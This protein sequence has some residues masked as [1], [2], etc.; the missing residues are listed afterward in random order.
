MFRIPSDL[1]I[2]V[3]GSS[4]AAGFG[5]FSMHRESQRWSFPAQ[6]ARRVK[7]PLIQPLFEP[8]GVGEAPG[9]QSQPVIFPHAQQASLWDTLPPA[10]FQ[11]LSV[12]GYKIHD[13]LERRPV[14]PMVHRNDPLQTACNLI[15]GARELPFG[16]HSALPT[17]VER[18]AARKPAAVLIELGYIEAIH[19]ALAG[20]VTGMMDG[21]A[22]GA[23]IGRILANFTAGF[24]VVFTVPDPFDAPHFC[25]LKA[26]GEAL[27]LDPAALQDAYG[28]PSGDLL[29]LP[30]LHEIAFQLFAGK[31]SPLPAGSL[32]SSAA[33]AAIRARVQE[34]NQAIH[35]VAQQHRAIVFD[36]HAV[37][38]GWHQNGA[39]AGTRR[40]SAAYLGGLFRLNGWFPGN[41]G[42]ALIADGIVKALMPA[43]GLTFPASDMQ[44]IMETDPAAQC[45]PAGGRNWTSAELATRIRV[46]PAETPAPEPAP[47]PA[48]TPAPLPSP[49]VTVR[50]LPSSLRLPH[51]LEQVLP[52][53]PDAS[54]FGDGISASLCED[55]RDIRWGDLANH[56]FGGYAIVD[57]HLSGRLR[58]R[59]SPPVNQVTSFEVFFEGGFT[60]EDS[61]LTCPIF[62]RMPFHQNRVDEIPG[63]VS[64]GELNLETGVVSKLR[65]YARYS[66]QALIA[67]VGSN[68]KFP[69]DPLSFVS[70]DIADPQ[71]EYGSAWAK[72]TQ[73]PDGALDFAFYGTRYVPLGPGTRWPLNFKGPDGAFATI[74]AD[75][76]VMHPHLRLST[77]ASDVAHAPVAPSI[78]YNSVREFTFHSHNTAFGDAFNLDI[79]E[80]GGVAKGRSHVMGRLMVQFGLPTRNTV[81][82]AITSLAPGGVFTAPLKTP[83]SEIFPGRLTPGPTGFNEIL[84]F[85]LRS[86]RQIELAILDDP[87]DVPIGALDLKTGGIFS[88]HLHR[89]FIEQNLIYALFHVEP[90]TPQSSFYFRGPAVVE[91][92][93]NGGLAFRQRAEV[94]VPYPKNFKFPQP[95]FANAY[96]TVRDC[97]LEPFLWI[98]AVEDESPGPS[99]LEGAEEN[100]LASTGE[101]FSYRFHI[102]ADPSR[103]LSTF[104]YTNHSQEGRFCL[105]SL[106]WVGFSKSLDPATQEV[107]TVTFAGFGSWEKAGSRTLQQAAAQICLNPRNRYVGIQIDSGDVSNVNTKPL[108]ETVALP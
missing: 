11:N 94:F 10:E 74:P 58:I 75:G 78:P 23:A 103:Q 95:N 44:L 86:Y 100:V 90:R 51:S 2:T 67:L 33:A 4:L 45:S 15:L 53:N 62:F 76:T 38:R 30:A 17:Q 68:P 22:F 99:G 61:V 72:F 26:A 79:R 97:A 34:W 7:A 20:T 27:R 19:A 88:E 83:I 65:I 56:I 8:P 14:A 70:L 1:N 35:R 9:F 92:N 106:A 24:V 87:F 80:L 6:I 63:K 64:T 29:R 102:P 39:S 82:I 32:L 46:V 73:R 101:V 52:L 43:A 37:F 5:D 77:V 84:R 91:R 47:T 104:E 41:T 89:G 54:Y 93:R 105:S 40:L 59:F 13:A 31:A 66:S 71:Q 69:Q 50:P 12:P 98:R 81:P 16:N 36:L 28:I 60:G 55:P 3:V 96:V 57:S 107:D 21:P 18:A 48:G 25:D 42:H 85:P 108:D 49:N